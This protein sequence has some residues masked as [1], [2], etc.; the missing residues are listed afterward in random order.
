[1]YVIYNEGEGRW[2]SG[3]ATGAG[4]GEERGDEEQ[5]EREGVCVKQAVLKGEL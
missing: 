2:K 1:M 4:G 3:L 5:G